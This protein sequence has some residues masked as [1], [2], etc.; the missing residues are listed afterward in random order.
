MLRKIAVP[1]AIVLV[2]LALGMAGADAQDAKAIIG[3][4]QSSDAEAG[5]LY[6][7]EF[8]ADGSVAIEI[9]KVDHGHFAFSQEDNK[10]AIY[11][12][13]EELPDAGEEGWVKVRIQGNKLTVFAEPELSVVLDRV[14]RPEKAESALIGRWQVNIEESSPE[15]IEDNEAQMFLT[16]NNNGSASYEKLIEVLA[17]RFELD[18]EA[19]S[20]KLVINDEAELGT[21]KIE[22]RQL[23]ISFDNETHVFERAE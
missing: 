7:A 2:M 18:P 19:G 22:D 11:E 5:E 10:L 21:Y 9:H 8:G 6:L 3:S 23:T 12:K 14:E 13:E 4:W 16:F 1:A 15:L 20:I 17:G